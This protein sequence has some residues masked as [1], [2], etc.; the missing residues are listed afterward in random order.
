MVE[1]VEIVRGGGSS[2]FGG[3]AIGGTVNVI[4]KD[5][6]RNGFSINSNLGLAGWPLNEGTGPAPD[7]SLGF[8]ASVVGD[9]LKSGMYLYGL[10]RNR[11]WFD[12]NEDEFS[13]LT[14]LNNNSAG[15][16]AYYRPDFVSKISFDFYTI[17]EKRRG[18]N[19]FDY[20]PH[21]TDITEMAESRIYG[22]GLAYERFTSQDR[23]NKISI[24]HS[25]QSID[26]NAYYGALMD[27]GAYGHTDDLLMVTGLQYVINGRTKPVF[28]NRLTM[29]VENNMGLLKDTKLGYYDP[30]DGVHYENTVLSY[31]F[32]NTAGAFLQGEWSPAKGLLVLAGVRGDYYHIEH[33]DDNYP[34]NSNLVVS[35][36]LNILY[37]ITPRIQ[38]RVSFS[39]GFR[40][41]QV[42]NEDLHILSS[43]ARRI[44]HA[45]DPDLTQENSISVSGSLDYT[46]SLADG[47]QLYFLAEGF[48][49][50][51]MNPFA[52][53]FARQILP[54]MIL[55]ITGVMLRERK[56]SERTWS[57][58]SLRHHS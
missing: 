44:I 37:D 1:R 52:D 42:F 7:A 3:N 18:G 5:P 38:S 32:S 54:R 45:N 25:M 28:P 15:L 33:I 4:T 40:A 34:V 43:G 26:R 35:P 6:V 14:R 2:L 41:P 10:S 17:Q 12:A 48:Y 23:D 22:G 30:A 24:Y 58:K 50:R 9:D 55:Y 29:G 21:E 46:A 51:L 47:T 19:K 27:P 11:D 8:N 49:T 39:T 36:R 13:E 56:Y 16:R 53:V 57:S 20:L 31:Q